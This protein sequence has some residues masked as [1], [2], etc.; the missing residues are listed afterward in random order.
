VIT[1]QVSEAVK[2]FVIVYLAGYLVR[3]GEQVKTD[4][5]AFLR[6]LGLICGA[7]FLLMME[8]DFGATVVIILTA[9]GML[10]VGGVQFRQ[11]LALISVFIATAVMLVWMSP[12]RMRRLTGFLNPWADPYN[13]GFQLSQSLIAIGSGSWGGVGLGSSVQ[14]LFYLP[15]SHTDFLFA[16]YAEETGLIGVVFL[17]LI[18]SFIV[19]RCIDIASKADAIGNRFGGFVAMGIGVW[20]GLQAFINMGVNMGILPTKG[21][22]LPL[23]SYG[24]SSVIIMCI[25]F[26]LLLRIDYETR[27]L[28]RRQLSRGLS[29]D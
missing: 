2:L 13:D 25:T 6:P 28:T 24:G 22:T 20:V 29:D 4:F 18:F 14:K 17:I 12:Y 26:S 5:G 9:M 27:I 11:F 23:M 1:V 16:V 8:P 3:R 19:W 15:E 10:F 7:G 21:I